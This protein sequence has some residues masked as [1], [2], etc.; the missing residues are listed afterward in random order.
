L[1]EAN[2]A[3]DQIPIATN[4]P[5][6][7]TATATPT[8]MP[9][10]TP[11]A[12]PTPVGPLVLRHSVNQVA[13]ISEKQYRIVF[14]LEVLGGMG[15]HLVYRDVEEQMV[16]GPGPRRSFTYELKWGAGYAAVGTF[17]ARSDGQRAES[18][19]YVQAPNCQP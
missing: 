10:A 9:T 7:P 5:P 8:A 11:T 14:G 2:R 17:H 19:F 1:V 12:V 6:P 3:L 16:Y 13:C 4:I 15:K 18:K